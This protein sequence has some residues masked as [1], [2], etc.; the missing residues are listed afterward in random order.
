[1]ENLNNALYGCAEFRDSFQ[2]LQATILQNEPVKDYFCRGL[3][4]ISVAVLLTQLKRE[5]CWQQ[6]L[7]ISRMKH[8]EDAIV[9]GTIKLIFLSESKF[10]MFNLEFK[11]KIS[12][13]FIFSTS[14]LVQQQTNQM[15]DNN[16]GL[17]WAERLYKYLWGHVDS[18]RGLTRDFLPFSYWQYPRGRALA[19]FS[20]CTSGLL[21]QTSRPSPLESYYR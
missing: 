14:L 9:L 2:I 8:H 15:K 16:E 17:G 18:F 7:F 1:M 6:C 20:C 13:C 3:T 4:L 11:E 5:G 19:T 21:W 10:V 12:N